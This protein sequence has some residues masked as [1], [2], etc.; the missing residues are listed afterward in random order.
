MRLTLRTLLAYLDDIL[1]PGQAREIGEKIGESGYAS[2]LVDRIREVMRR[3]RLTAPDVKNPG[4]GL[5]PNGV[6]EYL[7]NT[8][9]PEAVADV[10]KVC[11]DSDVHLA[12]VASCHQILTL[13]LGEPVD[14][15]ATTRERMYALGPAAPVNDSSG[16]LS[17]DAEG[18]SS[19]G[20]SGIG[21]KPSLPKLPADTD[22]QS[23]IPDYL[24]PP[25][26]WRRLAPVAVGVLIG[27][28]WLAFVYFD[29]SLPLGTLVSND[30][31]SQSI[32]DPSVVTPVT[33]PALVTATDGGGEGPRTIE[34]EVPSEP[35]LQNDPKS[36]VAQISPESSASP[37]S[38]GELNGFDPG[39]STTP[40]TTSLP[41]VAVSEP[42]SPGTTAAS[43]TDSTTPNAPSLPEPVPVSAPSGTQVAALTP[44]ATPRTP[45]AGSSPTA[46]STTSVV[47]TDPAE[48]VDNS[49]PAPEV[50]YTSRDGILARR[51]TDGW[52]VM[53]RRSV[54]RKGD[55]LAAPK[56]FTSLLE[57]DSLDLLI[58]LHGGTV[59]EFGGATKDEDVILKVLAGRLSV[60]RSS[61]EETTEPVAV[62][63]HLFDEP[64][65]LILQTPSSRF[66]IELTPEE[67]AAFERSLGEDRYTGNLY[68]VGGRAVFVASDG[69][70][71]LDA[72]SWFPL[73]PRDRKAL[74]A[75]TDRPPLLVVPD[76]L[77]P[78]SRP[79]S[80]TQRRYANRYEGEIDADEPLRN[81]VPSVVKSTIPGIS[82]L[83]VQTLAITE[84]Y[85]QLAQTLAEAQFVESRSAAITGL[86]RWL[87]KATE[88]RELLKTELRKH[89]PSSE[90]DNQAKI[91]YE[92][93]WGYD[94]DDARNPA[95]SKLLVS[96]LEHDSPVIRQLAF[97]H[98]YRLTGQRY[99]YR[100]I[101]PAN[102]RK[103]AVE[104]W[105]S[106]LQRNK[107]TL[108]E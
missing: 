77:D 33:D 76:W 11:L 72:P 15:P 75:T 17:D 43:T 47:A 71:T 46:P 105:L 90:Q 45:S 94:E 24:K 57:I 20:L 95:R 85:E 48:T 44:S 91:L 83:A 21:S 82:E 97:Q 49:V 28:T 73:T 5:D 64:C 108:L 67:P 55:R 84:Q 31:S 18:D 9:S 14:V 2:A 26:L 68:V 102:Q 29:P 87:P 98:I 40:S 10:E 80:S 54:I 3:R 13:V 62:G 60:Q 96:W 66:G 16:K 61:R 34:T 89:F 4:T 106:H 35:P 103:V 88:N 23:T 41:S 52:M 63:L 22:F 93:L 27:S 19:E 92:L 39:E 78:N 74:V 32:P 79:M 38:I 53:P 6:A 65:Q 104:R 36:L 12:E 107:G 58:E 37:R 8:L 7:D 81:S 70:E 56:P 69:E 1:E 86:R 59:I 50:L 42:S 25:P 101:N 99:D 100:P 30:G 51:T